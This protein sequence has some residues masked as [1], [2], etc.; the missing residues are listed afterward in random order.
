[1]FPNVATVFFFFWYHY[2]LMNFD[3]FQYSLIIPID[4]KIIPSLD[5]IYRSENIFRMAPV[6]F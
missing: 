6:L 2:E 5:A 3:I 4:T 1:M